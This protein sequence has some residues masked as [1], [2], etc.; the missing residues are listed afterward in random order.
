MIKDTLCIHLRVNL[1]LIRLGCRLLSEMETVGRLG[2][3][4]GRRQDQLEQGQHPG[5]D[6]RHHDEAG[7][8]KPHDEEDVDRGDSEAGHGCTMAETAA[9]PTLRTMPA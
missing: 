5:T 7:G 3:R 1:A 4:V 2:T 9:A 8:A 6:Q